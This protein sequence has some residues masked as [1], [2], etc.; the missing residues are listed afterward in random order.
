MAKSNKFFT[1]QS[2]VKWAVE[3]KH[4]T[5]DATRNGHDGYWVRLTSK[6]TGEVGIKHFGRT[7]AVCAETVLC[8]EVQAA[9]AECLREAQQV[10]K[11]K[12]AA[13]AAPVLPLTY[14]SLTQAELEAQ[15]PDFHNLP[16]AWM[17]AIEAQQEVWEQAA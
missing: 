15:C 14:R 4:Y 3:T 2:D 17:D 6:A 9:H 10:T 7:L 13:Q 12:A 8:F 16:C 11:A 5:A 1:K